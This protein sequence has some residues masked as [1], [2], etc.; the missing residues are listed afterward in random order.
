[1]DL[2][3]RE[4]TI[5]EYHVRSLGT[6]AACLGGQFIFVWWGKP[7]HPVLHC[8][9]RTA[10]T[11]QTITKKTSISTPPGFSTAGISRTSQAHAR[12]A[13]NRIAPNHQQKHTRITSGLLAASPAALSVRT[14]QTRIPQLRM[15]LG[16]DAQK[17]P[18]RP[19]VRRG[20]MDGAIRAMASNL[21]AK[22]PP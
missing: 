10:R 21:R 2:L 20:R 12:I 6:N 9:G 14:F 13:P 4:E 1:M 17:L 16:P 19:D 15:A 3:G 22:R 8:R 7:I 5:Q 11:L 18:V